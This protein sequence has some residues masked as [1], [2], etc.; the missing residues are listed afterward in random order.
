MLTRCRSVWL[1]LWV[2]LCLLPPPLAWSA[3]L[4]I[5]G[6]RSISGRFNYCVAAGATNSYTC[7]I[8]PGI[9]T[10]YRDGIFFTFKSNDANTGPATLIVIGLGPKTIKNLLDATLT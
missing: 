5:N 7:T 3:G 2:F 8:T 1:W 6:D 10:S 4:L 9:G